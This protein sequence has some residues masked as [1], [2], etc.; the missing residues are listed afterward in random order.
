MLFALVLL[1]ACGIDRDLKR[2]AKT[3]QQDMQTTRS[4]I[5][6]ARD[7]YAAWKKTPEYERFARYEATYGWADQYA[8]ALAELDSAKAVW[9]E[10][11]QILDANQPEDEGK[12]RNKISQLRGRLA[13]ALEMSKQPNRQ[14]GLLRDLMADLPSYIAKAEAQVAEMGA[15]IAG[16]RPLA[17]QATADSKAYGWNKEKDIAERFGGLEKIHTDA[18]EALGSAKTQAIVKDANY[19]VIAMGIQ[20]VAKE[21]SNIE[22]AGE[23]VKQ[24]LGE[25]KRSYT[26]RLIDMKHVYTAAIGRSSW[27]NYY[28]YP[29]ETDY[30]Y[31][32]RPVDQATFEY[33]S[34]QSGDIAS[35]LHRPRPRIPD[36]MWRSLNLDSDERAPRG[37]DSAVFWVDE[38]EI[39]YYHRYRIIENGQTRETDWETVDD[40]VFAANIKNLGMDI[41][42]KPY[43]MYADEA[44]KAAM[45][46]GM[47]YVGNEQYGRWQRDSAGNSFWA[48]YGRYAFLNAMLG[49]NRYYY[50]D[51]DRWRRDYRGRTPYYGKNT[52]GS[53]RYGTNGSMVR[54]DPAYRSSTFARQ[55]GIKAAPANVRSGAGGVRGRGPG[56][57]GK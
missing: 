16:I 19:A 36:S 53:A 52:D 31:A 6:S 47:A 17:D 41:L 38:T 23:A 11:E 9:T 35:G 51:W 43:G 54:N 44:M 12:L 21:R 26:K 49:G 30:V 50:N 48:F 7:K 2:A 37:D 40:D 29:K 39:K 27:D 18:A 33:L 22:K 42:S 15:I 10:I 24:R 32:A 34:K 45:P 46:P 14:I 13:K 55:G 25:L 3:R 1:V 8:A 20:R 28:D 56:S 4:R 5:E 57:R